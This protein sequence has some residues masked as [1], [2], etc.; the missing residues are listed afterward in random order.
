MINNISNKYIVL[1]IT[2]INLIEFTGMVRYFIPY[3][4]K[5]LQIN[6]IF[7]GIDKIML[8]ELPFRHV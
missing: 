4:N 6:H 5:Y 8:K 1:N 7:L 3:K 2:C